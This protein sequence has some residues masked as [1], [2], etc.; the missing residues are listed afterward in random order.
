[1]VIEK[2]ATTTSSPTKKKTHRKKRQPF[3]KQFLGKTKF[4][5]RKVKEERIF[6]SRIRN[7]IYVIIL[8]F[9]AVIFINL[10]PNSNLQLETGIALAPKKSEFSYLF[11]DTSGNSYSLFGQ[12]KEHGAPQSWEYLFEGVDL[13]SIH[14]ETVDDEPLS[15]S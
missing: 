9:F 8:L 11:Y 10:Q 5:I 7:T 3:S 13:E 2:I 14:N 4:K 15:S 1:M 6:G 12:S